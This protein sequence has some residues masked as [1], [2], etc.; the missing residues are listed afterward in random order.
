MIHNHY[1]LLAGYTI[2]LLLGNYFVTEMNNCF[3]FTTRVKILIKECQHILKAPPKVTLARIE[4]F[5]AK[6][7]WYSFNKT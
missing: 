4:L 7:K 2:L 5:I 3:F 1:I 6:E